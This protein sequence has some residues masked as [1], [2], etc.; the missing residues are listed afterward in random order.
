MET[1]KWQV[2]NNGRL[3]KLMLGGQ[4]EYF[5]LACERVHK[6]G[7]PCKGERECI[8]VVYVMTGRRQQSWSIGM[9]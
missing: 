2:L 6:L 9:I 7:T 8:L 3:E 4:L 1:L 5:K